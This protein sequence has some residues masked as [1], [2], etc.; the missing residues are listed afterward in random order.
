MSLA[1]AAIAFFASCGFL[2]AAWYVY[3][4]STR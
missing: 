2:L 3:F 4:R 1:Q